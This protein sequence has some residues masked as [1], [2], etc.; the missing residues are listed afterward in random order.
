M[1]SKI[2]CKIQDG[3]FTNTYFTYQDLAE[4]VFENGGPPI[5]ADTVGKAI[6]R[7]KRFR[8]AMA[9]PLEDNRA[10]SDPV[11]IDRYFEQLRSALTNVPAGMV[12][13]LDEMG[14]QEY[15]DAKPYLVVVPSDCPDTMINPVSRSRKR[16]SV[17]HCISGDGQML[18]PAFIVPR[19]TIERE[20]WDI[21][22]T[23]EICQIYYQEN[24]F[25]SSNVFEN[26]AN[27]IL[28]PAIKEKLTNLRNRPNDKT[29]LAH[30]IMD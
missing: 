28:F 29:L 17:I 10:E 14:Y 23:P 18:K 25:V 2:L 9:K 30:L 5:S 4:F 27:S 13:N 21:G 8:V 6:R 1:M 22:L 19:K 3:V 26:Y 20:V 16:L 11:E 12:Y 7:D 24:G 15:C